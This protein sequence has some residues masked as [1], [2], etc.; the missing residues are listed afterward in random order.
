[1]QA[2]AESASASPDGKPHFP[3]KAKSVICIFL[4]GGVSHVESFDPKPA[5][6]KYAGKSIEDTPFKDA[7]NPEKLRDVLAGNPAHGGRKILM[8]LNTGYK[9]YGQCGLEVG[10]WWP[11]VGSCADDL[12][13][14]RSLWTVHN[15]HGAQLT[16][17]TGRHPREG[18][19]PTIGSWVSYGLGT[20]NQNLP[21]YVVL[22]TPT[23]DCC[24]GEWTHG[25]SYLGPEHA[26][27]R[28]AVGGKEPLPFV[29]PPAGVTTDEQAA[30]FSLLGRLNRLAGIDYP[31]DPALRARIKAYELAF[32][33]QTA[34][35]E[36]LE[37][38]K[39]PETTRR[40]YGLDQSV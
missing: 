10:D 17:H 4:C 14:V 15:D 6:I 38:E 25:A 12:A 5:L 11:H 16:W 2:R 23:G 30:E 1:G 9:K 26:G 7:L 13:V 21:E 18:A 28:L 22:G 19:Y 31:D 37:L 34:V 33:M 39:E 3:A 24:G 8:A 36:T 35:P 29:R 20:L 40:L 32:G 27:V